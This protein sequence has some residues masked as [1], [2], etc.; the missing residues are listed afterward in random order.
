[1][2]ES[3]ADITGIEMEETREN[4]LVGVRRVP[5]VPAPAADISSYKFEQIREGAPVRHKPRRAAKPVHGPWF[6]AIVILEI[7]VA[8]LCVGVLVGVLIGRAVHG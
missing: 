3:P 5:Y 1:M 4:L 2:T 7:L 8:A 6:W